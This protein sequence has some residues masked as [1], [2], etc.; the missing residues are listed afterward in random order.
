MP[1]ARTPQLI[2]THPTCN[3]TQ[4]KLAGSVQCVDV[5]LA[6]TPHVESNAKVA[7]ELN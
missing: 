7:P 5:R 4:S 1:L 2:A 6:R 3:L